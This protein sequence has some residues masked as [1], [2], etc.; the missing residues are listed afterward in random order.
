MKKEKRRDRKR[1][2]LRGEW[3]QREVAR[4]TIFRKRERERERREK[5]N[6]TE[7]T[8]RL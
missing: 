8:K 3:E 2:K 4:S 5:G 7:C 1:N 6:I